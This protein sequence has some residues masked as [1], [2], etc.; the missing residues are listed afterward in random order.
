VLRG[1]RVPEDCG[2]FGR[3]CTLATPVGPCMVS[4]EGTCAAH[5]RYQAL[6][7]D[8]VSIAAGGGER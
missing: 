7:E 5:L 8:E 1:A 3:E 6:E 4:S 2:L